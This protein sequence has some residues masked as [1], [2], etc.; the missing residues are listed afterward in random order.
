[1][2]FRG[3]FE[4]TDGT[5]TVDLLGKNVGAF[6]IKEWIPTTPAV[7]GEG[8]WLDNPLIDGRQ[9]AIRKQT[10]IIENFTLTVKGQSQ[11]DIYSAIRALRRMLDRAIKFWTDPQRFTSPVYLIIQY[12]EETQAY[13]SVVYDYRLPAYADPWNTPMWNGTHPVTDDFALTIERGYRVPM[14]NICADLNY[15]YVTFPVVASNFSPAQSADDARITISTTSISLTSYLYVG[16]GWGTGIRFDNVTIPAGATITRARLVVTSHMAPSGYKPDITFKGEANVAPAVFSTYANFIGRTRTTASYVLAGSDYSWENAGVSVYIP[17]NYGLESIIQ[18]IIDLPGW[19]SGNELVMFLSGN[20]FAFVQFASFDNP[21]YDPPVLYV[22]YS[23]ESKTIVIDNDD[24]TGIIMSNEDKFNDVGT[25]QFYDDS[26]AAYTVL[27]GTALPWTLFP[28]IPA[29]DDILY[30]ACNISTA[31]PFAQLIFNLTTVMIN[32]TLVW[33]YYD[34]AGWTALASMVDKTGDLTYLGQNAMHFLPSDDWATFAVNGVTAYWIRIRISVAAGAITPPV[35]DVAEIQVG[36]RPY[37]DITSIPESDASCKLRVRIT[38]NG[39]SAPTWPG[40]EIDQFAIDEVFISS[41]SLSRGTDFTPYI[42]LAGGG[43][44]T[45]ITITPVGTIDL[46]L[47]TSPTG[48]TLQYAPAGVEVETDRI[49]ITLSAPII[50]QYQGKFR[51]M[52]RRFSV[53]S[54]ENISYRLRVATNI[55][56]S[57][58]AFYQTDLI[59]DTADLDHRVVDFGVIDLTPPPGTV[60]ENL[61]IVISTDTLDACEVLYED[62]IL[63]P[64]DEMFIHAYQRIG[65]DVTD[66]IL[67]YDDM[68]IVLDGVSNDDLS[69]Y[70][71]KSGSVVNPY[72][73]E[74]NSEFELDPAGGGKRLWFF[75][76]TYY[77]CI[78]DYKRSYSPIVG[79]SVAVEIQPKLI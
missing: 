48:V 35:Q 70:V 9:L 68:V 34:G 71:E 10:N 73:Y 30:I 29:V 55:T 74:S 77:G 58:P 52:L 64:A 66:P 50:E 36:N 47:V 59:V 57:T 45:G 43:V 19:A 14:G 3:R 21:A 76:G 38:P 6:S 15:D 63:L 79:W 24:C 69:V 22:E 61:Y 8:I 18:E 75:V 16:Q 65:S 11:S 32:A 13:Q 56:G 53:D 40:G 51:A 23:T 46:V 60:Y 4:L 49:V 39:A 27:N 54:P 78:V 1:M 42:N 31:A 26:L 2:S 25:V 33:E 17:P 37:I 12:P 5:T 72:L 41:R 20:D 62:L 44:P 7:K 28:A 67:T